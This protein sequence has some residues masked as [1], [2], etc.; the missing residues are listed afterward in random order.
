MSS[1]AVVLGAE[2][3]RSLWSSSLKELGRC[4]KGCCGSSVPAVSGAEVDRQ[5]S[6]RTI[7]EL[8]SCGAG[9]WRSSVAGMA[10]G[11]AGV[12]TLRDLGGGHRGR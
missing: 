1:V 2:G 6:S 11:A 7:E 4:G 12:Q 5:P 10:A 3:T 9:R 8:G